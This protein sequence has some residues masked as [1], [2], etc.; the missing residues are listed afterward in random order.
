MAWPRL[1][2]GQLLAHGQFTALGGCR[3]T[4]GT[5]RWVTLDHASS[6][7]AHAQFLQTPPGHFSPLWRLNSVVI[8]KMAIKNSHS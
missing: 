2:A 4:G 8:G 1:P 6:A 3:L 5:S 7:R